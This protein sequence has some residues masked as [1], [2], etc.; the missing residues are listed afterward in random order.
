MVGFVS[1]PSHTF[2]F[3][4]CFNRVLFNVATC[5]ELPAMSRGYDSKTMVP[6]AGKAILEM[7]FQPCSIGIYLELLNTYYTV[8]YR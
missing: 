5:S 2:W 1:K 3:L 8:G 7:R 4:L 6:P